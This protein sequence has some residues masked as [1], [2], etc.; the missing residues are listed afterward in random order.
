MSDAN[1][2]PV[3]K[4]IARE[5]RTHCSVP[6]SVLHSIIASAIKNRN[7]ELIRMIVRD[8]DFDIDWPITIDGVTGTTI[9][10]T[11]RHFG[12]ET[13]NI[14]LARNPSLDVVLG[15]T[16]LID[17]AYAFRLFTFVETCIDRGVSF[18]INAP[19][20]THESRLYDAVY[21][22]DSQMITWLLGQNAVVTPSIVNMMLRQQARS[23]PHG[24]VVDRFVRDNEPGP[25]SILDIQAAELLERIGE[26]TKTQTRNKFEV[27]KK[28]VPYLSIPINP[29]ELDRIAFDH[30]AR[31]LCDRSDSSDFCVTDTNHGSW[32]ELLA[33]PH[34]PL[35]EPLF[36]AHKL[37][38]VKAKQS[39]ATIFVA[40]AFK[41]Q[42]FFPA[43]AIQTGRIDLSRVPFTWL[44]M[45]WTNGGRLQS[46]FESHIAA[47]RRFDPR[48]VEIFFE[49]HGGH[50]PSDLI[51]SR[52]ELM[53]RCYKKWFSMRLPDI[54]AT[55]GDDFAHRYMYV[56]MCMKEMELYLPIE[57][58]EMVFQFSV[59]HDFVGI[60]KSPPNHILRNVA[61]VEIR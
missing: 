14:V 54:C 26:A 1:S 8:T 43:K 36:D 44:E 61:G 40:A 7:K 37:C 29:A 33:A 16:R 10:F 18:D 25:R 9:C 23:I 11:Y 22:A 56:S 32:L 39:F 48:L 28:L 41:T 6:M 45:K 52:Q 42:H 34:M 30:I 31:D 38:G 59:A 51:D 35:Y 19:Y 13:R 55:R 53:S 58:L 15:T 24:A 4:T 57:L 27:F 17:C 3:V 50:I 20:G 47:G 49:F 2:L 60:F 21:R 5:E 46:Y 12:S